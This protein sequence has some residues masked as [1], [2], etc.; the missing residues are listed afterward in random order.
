MQSVEDG[1][2]LAD[3]ATQNGEDVANAEEDR[4]P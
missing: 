2:D 4:V 1:S 3:H